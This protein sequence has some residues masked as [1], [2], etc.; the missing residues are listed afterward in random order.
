VRLLTDTREVQAVA[1]GTLLR[2]AVLN[3]VANAVRHTPADGTVHIGCDRDPAGRPYVAVW[4]ACGGIPEA[5]LPRVFDAGYRGEESRT[6]GAEVGAGLGLA[7][8]QGIVHAHAG[9]VSV[10]NE[11]AGCVFTVLLP[12]P[13]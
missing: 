3:L 10:R 12:Q 9:S 13:A 5:D 6:P 2:R 1:D 4:D 11:G 7:I 8:A